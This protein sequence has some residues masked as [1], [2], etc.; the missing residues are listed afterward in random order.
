[1]RAEGR[2]IHPAATDDFAVPRSGKP[3]QAGQQT[4]P[5]AIWVNFSS[6]AAPFC[7]PWVSGGFTPA[8]LKKA[9][10]KKGRQS[11]RIADLFCAVL[12]SKTPLQSCC[13][14]QRGKIA[15]RSGKN[16]RRL[17]AAMFARSLVRAFRGTKPQE[18]LWLRIDF[19]SVPHTTLPLRATF[20]RETEPFPSRPFGPLF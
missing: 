16:S 13:A 9:P 19:L 7:L 18:F 8:L 3:A 10:C 1:M 15:M 11:L 5:Q 14:V 2:Q 17:P 12:L 20:F 6:F 4:P